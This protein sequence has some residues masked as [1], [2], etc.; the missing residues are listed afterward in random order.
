MVSRRDLVL[1]EK[2][3]MMGETRYRLCIEGTN[4][5][6]NVNAAEEE[7][8]FNK[9]LEILEKIGMTDEALENI[10]GLLRSKNAKDLCSKSSVSPR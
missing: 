2:Y 4:I 10:R 6:I 9:A 5:V 8:A 1:L 7:E 3:S